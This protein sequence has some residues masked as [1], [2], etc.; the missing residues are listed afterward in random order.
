MVGKPLSVVKD[1]IEASGPGLYIVG[2]D[3]HVGFV[4]NREGELSFVHSSYYDPPRSVIKEQI[5]GRNPLADSNYR[6]VGKILGD[7]MM[8]KWLAGEAFEL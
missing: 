1:Y 4:L 8:R 6:V 2:L 5:D 3:T 7:E